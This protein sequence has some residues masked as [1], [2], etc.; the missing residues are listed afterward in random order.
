MELPTNNKELRAFEGDKNTPKVTY[1]EGYLECV[2]GCEG[3]HSYAISTENGKIVAK[4]RFQDGFRISLSDFDKGYYHLTLFD[5]MKRD[6]F[7]FQVK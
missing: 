4:G 2:Y 3:E 1:H 6:I 7:A 5:A